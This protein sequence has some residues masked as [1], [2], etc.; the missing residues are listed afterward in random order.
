MTAVR[1][2]VWPGVPRLQLE[3]SWMNRDSGGSTWSGRHPHHSV[4]CDLRRSF[5][6]KPAFMATSSLDLEQLAINTIRTLSM[7][8]VQ[9]ANSGHPGT[10][11]ALAPLAYSIWQNHLRYDPEHPEWPARDRFV[12]SCGHAS[13]LLY[14]VLHLAGVKQ[15][16][17]GKP[18]GELAVPLDHIRQFRQ[19]GS[20][21]PGHPEFHWTSGVDVTTG[22]L[23]QGI[24]TSVGMAI[25]GKWLKAR[26]SRPGFDLFGFNTFAIC[27]D[28]D[29]MEGVGA[30]A[31]SIAGHMKLDNLCWFYDDNNITIEGHTHLAFSENVAERFRGL[32]WHV[33]QVGDVND[34]A[35]LNAAI[36]KFDQTADKPTLVI[37]KSVIGYGSPNKSNHHD[38]HGAPLGDAEIKLTKEAYGWP[39]EE[40]FLVPDEVREHFASG[41]GKRGAAAYQAWQAKIDEYAKAFPA[42]AKEYSQ[43]VRRELPPGWDADLP[44]FPADAKGDATRN[45]GGKALNAVAK[46]IPWLLGGSADLAPSTKTLLTFD[47]IPSFSP[48]HPE[49][50]NFHWGIREHGMAAAVNGLTLCGLRG[51]GATFFVFSDYCR[52]SLRLAAIM[53]IPSVFVFTHDSIGVGEDGPTHQPVEHLAACRA[54]PNLLVM[55]PGDAN[56]VS[57]MWRM[58]AKETHRPA[59]LVLTRQNLPTLDRRKF[60]PAEM[61]DKGGYIL[62]DPAEGKP[63]VILMASGSELSIA[64][65]AA[66][67]LS[68]QGVQARVVSM[69]CFELFEDQDA[70]Y[71]QS[72]LPREIAARVAVE[73]GIR[74]CWDRYLGHQG[75]FVGMH[76]YGASAP[77]ATLYKKFGITAEDVASAAKKSMGR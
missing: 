71:K 29:L 70:A 62:S 51:Y 52:P 20:R 17:N 23:G 46:H 24:G 68:K 74:Q 59:C 22:P 36:S 33:I 60:A 58:I 77:Y 63:E 43:M 8:G 34:R 4:L 50:R 56:E 11:M 67:L 69:P 10:P 27:S 48:E 75:E 35:L 37:V 7:D 66:D 53:G 19:W 13:M 31:A 16:K 57:S 25:A 72:V 28:G 15:F 55:R 45:T 73:A 41:V 44:V 5:V 32:G 39:A 14:S 76:S 26:Y 30:E 9:A 38:A 47:K 21:C 3:T 42:E 54:I 6:G 64:V 1:L 65:D 2:T 49:G 40:K 61:A 12:L 18:T